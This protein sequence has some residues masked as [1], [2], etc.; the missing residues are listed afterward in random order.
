M[1]TD[2]ELLELAAKVAGYC[3]ESES[4]AGLWVYEKGAV[5]DDDDGEY[6]LIN[7]NPLTD[8]GDASRL[9]VS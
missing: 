9:A 2:R 7:W 1:T 3:V 8:A 5:E 6:P 4:Y